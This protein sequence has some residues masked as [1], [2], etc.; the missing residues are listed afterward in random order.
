MVSRKAVSKLHRELERGTHFNY[1]WYITANDMGFR[2]GY[3]RVG[4]K[5]PWFLKDPSELQDIDVHGGLTWL[6]KG[7]PRRAPKFSYQWWLGFDCAHYN[8]ANDV[9]LMSEVMKSTW[10][11]I[12]SLSNSDMFALFGPGDGRTIRSQDY[13]RQECF[14]LC[15][16]AHVIVESMNG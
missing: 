1:D 3:I 4:K 11:D 15:E 9:T 10:E 7:P 8:D 14:K 12:K 13:V 2:C 6:D 5:H 16:Q